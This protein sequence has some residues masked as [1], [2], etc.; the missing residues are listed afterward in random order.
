MG[1][2]NYDVSYD[3]PNEVTK[4]AMM[5]AISGHNPNKVYSSV[6]EMVED[7]LNEDN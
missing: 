7:I 3:E 2:I 4:V 6:D 1:N 5:E